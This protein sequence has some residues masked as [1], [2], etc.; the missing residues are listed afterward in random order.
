MK[1]RLFL[2][3]FWQCIR[4]PVPELSL[5]H[6]AFQFGNVV[7]QVIPMN[8]GRAANDD[9]FQILPVLQIK[10]P[11]GHAKLLI[12]FEPAFFHR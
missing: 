10:R 2:C 11:V 5:L 7:F 12:E 6:L 3:V 4:L 8:T 9:G 1:I